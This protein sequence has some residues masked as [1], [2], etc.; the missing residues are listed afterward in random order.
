MTLEQKLKHALKSKDS[1]A[2]HLVFEEIYCTYGKLIY[3]TIMQYVKNNMDVEDFTQEVFLSFFNNLRKTEIKNIK[4]YLV[5]SAKN[6]AI[7]FIKS[8]QNK[9]ILDENIIYSLE[10][11]DDKNENYILII[12]NMKKYL[13]NNEI[14]IIIQHSIYDYSFKELSLK[15]NK[16]INTIISIYHRAIKKYLKGVSKNEKK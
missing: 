5:V 12:S 8:H 3:F 1:S 16:S 6:R 11:V 15:Y 14:D 7:N 10:Q 2:I 9:F 4:Y 13:N